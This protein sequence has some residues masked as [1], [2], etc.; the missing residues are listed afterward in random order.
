MGLT[1]MRITEYQVSCLPLDGTERGWGGV[2]TVHVQWSEIGDLWAV[3]ANG[4]V[5]DRD[6]VAEY[7]PIPSERDDAFLE[8][9]RMDQTTAMAVAHRV[10][11]LITINGT[12]AALAA[13]RLASAVNG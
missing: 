13:E 4:R 3:R 6:G 2:F 11:P 9:F 10:A 12:T 7:E 1:Q 8:R 5:Y